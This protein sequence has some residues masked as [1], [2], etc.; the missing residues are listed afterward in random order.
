MH[1]FN[2]ELFELSGRRNNGD[3]SINL[4]LNYAAN[5]ESPDFRV[6]KLLLDYAAG[7]I[8]MFYVWNVI[9]N[10]SWSRAPGGVIGG[11]LVERL[12]E[13]E[14]MVRALSVDL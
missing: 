9:K 11:H 4:I 12:V 6:K 5:Y 13:L 10:K 8:L 7:K 1:K 3:H 2:R 14:A